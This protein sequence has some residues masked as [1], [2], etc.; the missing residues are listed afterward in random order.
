MEFV[1]FSVI[2]N[3]NW[4]LKANEACNARITSGLTEEQLMVFAVGHLQHDLYGWVAIGCTVVAILEQA[5][6]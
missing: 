1:I 3:S 4:Y 2:I 5:S 6:Q